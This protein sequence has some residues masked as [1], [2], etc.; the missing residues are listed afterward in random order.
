MAI[1]F[2]TSP[3]YDDYD[4]TKGYYRILFKPGVSVQARELTQLQTALQK[5]VE[6]VGNYFFRDG[7]RVFGAEFGYSKNFKAIKLQDTFGADSVD[8]YIDQLTNVEIIGETSGVKAR[9]VTYTKS[10]D[11]DPPTI[12]VTYTQSTQGTG[13][14]VGTTATEFYA[15]EQIIAEFEEINNVQPGYPILS[16]AIEDHAADGQ[17]A[18]IETGVYFVKGHFVYTPAQRV[19]ISK[20]TNNV[21]CRIGLSVDEAIVTTTEDDSLLDNAQ[22]S[23]NFTASG[24]DR[25]YI[26]LDLVTYGLDEDVPED[27]IELQRINAGRQVQSNDAATNQYSE[28]ERKMAQRAAETTGDYV[29]NQFDVNIRECLNDGTNN[30]VFDEGALTDSGNIADEKY[31]TMQISSGLAYISGFRVE[32]IAPTFVDILKPR[33]YRE[34]RGQI[35]TLEMGNYVRLENTYNLPDTTST[36]SNITTFAPIIL[37]DAFTVTR[38]QAAGSPIGVAR[39]RNIETETG[40]FNQ[41]NAIL[42]DDG[43]LGMRCFIFDIKMFTTVTLSATA[44]SA[45]I[46]AGSKITGAISGAYGFVNSQSTGGTLQ[47]TSVVGNFKAGETLRSSAS[48]ETSGVIENAL[49]TAVGGGTVITVDSS[50]PPVTH[51]FDLV[52]QLYQAKSPASYNFTSDLQ[53]ESALNLSGSVSVPSG[54]N[55]TLTGFNTDFHRE[56]KA[57]DQIQVPTA[58]DGTSESFIVSAV[59]SDNELALVGTAT[60]SVTS[61]Q[62]TRYR[63]F[64]NDQEKNLALRKLS[65]DWARTLKT[66]RN[67]NESN[68][69]LTVR[70]EYY[71]QT[72]GNGTFVISG[73]ADTKFA[74]RSNQDYQISVIAAGSGSAADGDIINVESASIDQFSG[75]NTTGSGLT[76]K[77]SSLFG[78]SAILKVM[79]TMTKTGVESKI[80]DVNKA[81][82]IRVFNKKNWTYAATADYD[83]GEGPMVYGTSAHHQDIS[84]GVADVSAILG[85]FDSGTPGTAPIVP[86]IE[87]GGVVTGNFVRGETV[88][89]QNS[90]AVAV[91]ASNGYQNSKLEVVSI[92]N[93]AF[94]GDELVTGETS[95]AV[96]TVNGYTE[97]SSNIMNNF[98]LD[99]GQR[100]NFYDLSRLVYKPNVAK[101]SGD[102]IVVFD[103]FIN[104]GGGTDFYSVDSYQTLSYKEI[105]QYSATRIDPEVRNADGLYD[106][107]SSFDF[108]PKVADC[109]DTDVDSD[110]NK[111][112]TGFTLDFESRNYTEDGASRVDVIK[113]NDT[114]QYDFEYYLSRISSVFLTS[115]GIFTVVDGYNAEDPEVPNDLNEAM[116][117]ADIE[118]PPYVIDVEDVTN[119]EFNNKLY[120]MKD[121]QLLEN[122]I[123]NI[124]YY[125]AMT[126][127][128]KDAETMQIK[129]A[130]GLDRFKSGFLV[131]NFGGHKIG[132]TVHQD[133][134]CSIDMNNRILRPQYS[135][136]P[137]P[138]IEYALSDPDPD[139]YRAGKNYVVKDDMAYLP[140]DHVVSIEQKFGTRVENLNPVLSFFWEGT[141]KLSPS[142]D[143]W[144]KNTYL[145]SIRINV[146]GN[147]NTLLKQNKNALGT[148]WDAPVTNWSGVLTNKRGTGGRIYERTFANYVRGKGR[149]VLQRQVATEVGT[150]KQNGIQTSIVE[151]I[152]YKT[153]SNKIVGTSLIPYMREKTVYFEASGLKPYTRVYPFFDKIDVS[154]YV[155][156]ASGSY[157]NAADAASQGLKV[158][159]SVWNSISK[160]EV[161][162]DNNSNAGFRMLFQTARDTDAEY[163]RKNLNEYWRTFGDKTV[164]SGRTTNYGVVTFTKTTDQPVPNGSGDLYIRMLLRPT[165][166][167]SFRDHQIQISEIKFYDENGTEIANTDHA[168][169]Y[170]SRNFRNAFNV[171]DGRVNYRSDHR[172]FSEA[173]IKD[174]NRNSNVYWDYRIYI[175]LTGGAFTIPTTSGNIRFIKSTEVDPGTLITDGSGHVAG[176]FELPD[177]NVAG[178]PKFQTG[179]REFRLTASPN[180]GQS[181]ETFATANYTAT[182]I[183]RTRQATIQATR[184]ARIERKSVS[185]TTHVS[186]TVDQGLAQV[187]WYDPVAQSIMP[188][189]EGGEFITKVEVY[190]SQKDGKIPV[191]CQIRTMSDGTPTTTVL[192]DAEVTIE[193]EDVQ[194]SA[195]GTLPTVFEFPHPIYVNANEEIAIVLIS[196]SQKYLV[197]ISRLGE[198]DAATGDYVS[199]QPYLGVLFKSQNNSTW[200]A[201]DLEDLKF[202]VYRASFDTAVESD[203]EM[204]NDVLPDE[205]LVLNPLSMVAGSNTIKVYHQDHGM[206]GVGNVVAIDGATSGIAGAL[207]ADME[208]GDTTLTFDGVVLPYTSGYHYFRIQTA[209][210]TETGDEVVYGE[211]TN[212]ASGVTTVSNLQRGLSQTNDSPH[213]EDGRIE[214]YEINGIPLTEINTTHVVNNQGMDYYTITTTTA[215]DETVAM[216]GSAVTA[217]ENAVVDAYQLM[218]PIIEYPDTAIA[219]TKE[220]VTG[221]SPSGDQG[222]FGSGAEEDVTESERIV[223]QEP[224]LICSQ[225][226]EDASVVNN[227]GNKSCVIHAYM[228]STKDNLSPVVDLE[229]KSLVAYMNRI[230]MVNDENDVYPPSE[231]V[232]ATAPEGDSNES[233]YITKRVQLKNPATAIRLML[234]IVRNESAN[235]QCMFKTLRSDDST[236]FDEIGWTYFNEAGEPDAP[237][238]PVDNRT[239]FLEYEY[240]ANEQPEFIAFAIKIR[241]MGTNGCEVPLIKNLRAIALA[242]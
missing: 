171:V 88:K 195:D 2:D 91:V 111:I 30:G 146:E 163:G 34:A 87:F 29:L 75:T 86:F 9:V 225:V 185:R 148:V 14:Q 221:T 191:T 132:D 79:V 173:W 51:T 70:R 207:T 230:N 24:A 44:A 138:L 31:L 33:D 5:Q 106:L 241:M 218:L 49:T 165:Q 54:V 36:S 80:K 147:Y 144:F 205:T 179:T 229:R 65:K 149:R 55:P 6:R 233:V 226:N 100:D 77:S 177:P 222:S 178:N 76:V 17:S 92:N 43:N 228:T 123:N 69:S 125:T 115:S 83:A 193:P 154:K 116:R 126:L 102:L 196:N 32:T 124:E 189:T 238:N 94:I 242:V 104:G 107:R 112:I 10:T 119:N 133:Y 166:I 68:S 131:D 209:N 128:E 60:S 22:G 120:S 183:L 204:V 223:N 155:T 234:D 45:Q 8:D 211:I 42:S 48:Y 200:T 64:I 217:S 214:L 224:D 210:S 89:G 227:T 25:Y 84:L 176:I 130:Y 142:Q 28:F 117:I 99:T 57:G 167:P 46:T 12:Y 53:L 118:M 188:Q 199:E 137:V 203:I 160:I 231:F 237:I 78:D 63:A 202:K 174:N 139:T 103:S 198:E 26:G 121:I 169:V 110:G 15:N 23:P 82:R 113:D 108:R 153:V 235:V 71:V 136:K 140:Y 239:S 81:D 50:T 40:D 182:G 175:R 56:V 141:L 161:Y 197:W 159:E 27:F 158:Q 52:K 162:Y 157:T 21:S 66:D 129:D 73:L 109:Q 151:Q 85:V 96:G 47:L 95:G 74:A 150:K 4:E 35:A 206:Y 19:I 11:T 190:F 143:E 187:G 41:N 201:Y 67:D 215:A 13:D 20:Y 1:N 127:L 213:F 208:A 156:Q 7:T 172:V 39:V 58:A 145:P 16:T 114:L 219:L 38:G 168:E 194:V 216:G 61:V 59:N 192:P 72:N 164:T 62:S 170:S 98:L 240:T 220:I 236:D 97:G 93:V 90:G 181:T 135:M 152:D 180:N 122:R 232:S 3:Y 134:R 18:S 212:V 186:R 101:A 105:P 184:N 37:R